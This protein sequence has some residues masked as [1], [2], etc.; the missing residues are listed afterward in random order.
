MKKNKGKKQKKHKNAKKRAFQLSVIFSFFGGC[1]KF[2][3]FD[4]LAKKARTQKTLF[5]IG[6]SATHFVENSS[7]SRNGRFWT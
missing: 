3:F 1:P 6:V 2:P 4:N 5:K 7:E